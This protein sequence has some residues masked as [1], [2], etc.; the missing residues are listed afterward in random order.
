MGIGE[1]VL[2]WGLTHA[3]SVVLDVSLPCNLLMF[4]LPVLD[5]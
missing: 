3:V 1:H 4:K 2:I 5:L